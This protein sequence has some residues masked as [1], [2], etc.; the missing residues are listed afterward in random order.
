[1]IL[2]IHKSTLYQ[3]SEICGGKPCYQQQ[4]GSMPFS[5]KREAWCLLVK[6]NT[7]EGIVDVDPAVVFD[8]A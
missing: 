5:D 1:V 6:D 4:S 8:E 2:D 3:Q 7:Q